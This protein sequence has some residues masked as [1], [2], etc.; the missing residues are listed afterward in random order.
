MVYLFLQKHTLSQII[1]TIF[2]LNSLWEKITIMFSRKLIFYIN[3]K[4]FFKKVMSKVD[5]S[6]E[7]Y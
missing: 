4:T 1:D 5:D 6:K 3:L 7:I 2:Q